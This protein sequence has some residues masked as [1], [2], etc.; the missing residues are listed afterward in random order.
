MTEFLKPA[1]LKKLAEDVRVAEARAAAAKMIQA[2]QAADGLR[3]AFESREVAAEAPE[4]INRAVRDAAQRGEHEILVLRFP[5]KYCR[6]GGRGINNYEPDWPDSLEGFGR[7]AFEFYAKELRPLGF[8]MRAEI[9]NFPQGMPGDV[10]MY[11]R[12]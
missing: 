7:T 9:M 8:T 10:G 5:A 2:E 1:D 3:Q 12:W 4:R 11:L 6:D